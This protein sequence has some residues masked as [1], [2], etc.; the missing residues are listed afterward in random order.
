MTRVVL[1][2]IDRHDLI[3]FRFGVNAIDCIDF[4]RF[5]YTARPMK[6]KLSAFLYWFPTSV[7]LLLMVGSGIMYLVNSEEV[8]KIFVEL[9]YPTFSMWF[10]AAAKILG[11]IALIFPVGRIWKE[12]AY[13]G[14]LYIMLMA[15]QAIYLRQSPL[16]ASIMVVF[17]G[18][19]LW[20]YLMFRKRAG[21]RRLPA[22]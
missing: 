14:Y 20:S 11:G 18:I 19:W 7:L 5:L 3:V 1:Q 6:N 9:G 12:W 2:G 22:P 15:T 4:F 8:A 10:N 16:N 21:T 17:L 13:A